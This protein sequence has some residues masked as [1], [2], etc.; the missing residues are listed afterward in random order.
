MLRPG[1]PMLSAKPATTGSATLSK[2]IGMLPVAACAAFT[3]IGRR[4]EDDI[5]AQLDQLIGQ[6]GQ[7]L[8][9]AVGKALD[10]N[11]VRPSP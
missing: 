9:P 2:T 6:R 1:R 5:D 10:E 8:V 7:A 11:E 4:R 3:A